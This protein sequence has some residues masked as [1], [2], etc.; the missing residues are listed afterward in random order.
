[1]VSLHAAFVVSTRLFKFLF[2][3]FVLA[4]ACKPRRCD[5]S[6]G[7]TISLFELALGEHMSATTCTYDSLDRGRIFPPPVVC[8]RHVR[9]PQS[10]SA[11]F[12]NPASDLRLGQRFPLL[13]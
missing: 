13:G 7:V 10:A 3:P 4:S 8:E 6:P 1:M 12:A 5:L 2:H 11:L 9:L